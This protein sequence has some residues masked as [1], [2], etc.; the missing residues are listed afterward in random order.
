MNTLKRKN[1]MNAYNGFK[2]HQTVKHVQ[3]FIDPELFDR[4]TGK[5]LGLV[6]SSINTAYH[7]GRQSLNGIDL[8]DDAVWLPWGGG[9]Y[10]AEQALPGSVI[11]KSGE[12]GQLIPINALRNIKIDNNRYTLDFT[13]E[14]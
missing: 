5:E 2:G 13:D 7:A 10:D 11:P 3:S 12:T 6:M 14:L 9:K 4:L 1:M 8:C